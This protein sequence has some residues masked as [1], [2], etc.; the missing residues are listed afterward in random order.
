MP[1][2][3]STN[4]DQHTQHIHLPAKPAHNPLSIVVIIYEARCKIL[5]YCTTLQ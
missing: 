2:D 1:S 3:Q 5:T 4:T